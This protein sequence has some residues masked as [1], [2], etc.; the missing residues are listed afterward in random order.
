MMSAPPLAATCSMT[1]SRPIAVTC[2]AAPCRRAVTAA[3]VPRD[4]PL[5]G[6]GFL[7]SMRPSWCD[8]EP[9]DSVA[10]EGEVPLQ[11]GGAAGEVARQ[12]AG[13]HDA[14]GGEHVSAEDIGRVRVLRRRA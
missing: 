4:P 1:G 13:D 2:A 6:P 7:R 11:L 10:G 5:R 14:V 9:A 12:P 3:P 8:D